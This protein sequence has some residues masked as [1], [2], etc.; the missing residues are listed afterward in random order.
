MIYRCLSGS[1]QEPGRFDGSNLVAR[2][3][4]LNTTP[5]DWIESDPNIMSDPENSATLSALQC[6][7]SSFTGFNKENTLPS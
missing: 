3:G 2:L 1:I 5:I 6:R 7:F 4:Y